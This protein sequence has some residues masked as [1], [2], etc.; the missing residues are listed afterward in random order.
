MNSI[1]LNSV[2]FPNLCLT[3]RLMV[4]E[5][6]DLLQGATELEE[7][8]ESFQDAAVADFSD[9]PQF[10]RHCEL[11]DNTSVFLKCFLLFPCVLRVLRGDS[12]S[13]NHAFV[14][15]WLPGRGQF[16]LT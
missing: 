7:G 4:A 15:A 16:T 11:L 12:S 9:S 6:F 3:G 2:K 13:N 10:F 14:S 8:H 5:P 1:E